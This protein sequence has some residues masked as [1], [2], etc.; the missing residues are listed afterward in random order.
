M[1]FFKKIKFLIIKFFNSYFQIKKSKSL[2]SLSKESKDLEKPPSEK[3][4]SNNTKI[5]VNCF[6]LKS[7]SE[8]ITSEIPDSI[9]INTPIDTEEKIIKEEPGL[10]KISQNNEYKNLKELE[11]PEGD[12]SLIEDILIKEISKDKPYKRQDIEKI[13]KKE[14]NIQDLQKNISV[15]PELKKSSNKQIN[16]GEKRRYKRRIS[17]SSDKVK[18]LSVEEKKEEKEDAKK[19]NIILKPYIEFELDKQKINLVFPEQQFTNINYPTENW[20]YKLR[21]N[22]IEVSLPV[23]IEKIENTL[24]IKKKTH[25]IEEPIEN[26]TIKFPNFFNFEE[27]DYIHRDKDIYIFTSF[28]SKK[29]KMHYLYNA[30]GGVNPIPRKDIWVLLKDNCDFITNPNNTAE[31][32]FWEKYRPAFFKLKEINEL[33]FQDH[34]GILVEIPYENNFILEGSII[35]DGLF[36]ESPLF[37]GNLALLNSKYENPDG[38][39]IW[40]QNKQLGHDKLISNNWTGTKPLEIKFS[41]SLPC[42]FGEFQLSICTKNSKKPVDIIFFRYIEFIAFNYKNSLILPYENGHKDEKIQILFNED[43]GD[44]KIITQDTTE[45]IK[46]G[47]ELIIKEKDVADFNIANIHNPRIRLPIRIR[48]PKLLWK[49]SENKKFV[50]KEIDLTRDNIMINQNLFYMPIL[51]QIYIMKL[52]LFCYKITK[53]Y[54][55]LNLR[56]TKEF[57]VVS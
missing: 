38:W 57:I 39:N 20:S 42:R 40:I 28:S 12:T 41:D 47:Y 27:L 36:D 22:G 16:L 3:Q 10:I 4:V 49:L 17:K 15:K 25:K 2:E 37:I 30:T 31:L 53:N 33:I 7:I 56:K 32:W 11:E 35:K 6:K 44:W 55:H 21:L 46:E 48:I 14:E 50:D 1:K 5:K 45:K 9:Q 51:I 43:S 54:R 24:I 18:I 52:R 29:C 34:S 26:L 13:I 23:N 8:Q 19:K